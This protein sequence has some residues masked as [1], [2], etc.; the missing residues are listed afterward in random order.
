M[1]QGRSSPDSDLGRLPPRLAASADLATIDPENRK[2]A[3]Q[4]RLRLDA[5]LVRNAA[6]TTS[7]R[8]TPEVGGPSV[9][10]PQ[11]NG[12]MNL[13]QMRRAW[14]ADTGADCYRLG[15]YT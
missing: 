2:L 15:R 4:P 12:L 5:E 6:L 8:L 3:R 1:P 14:N 7:G 11:P 13:G 10:P 9:F